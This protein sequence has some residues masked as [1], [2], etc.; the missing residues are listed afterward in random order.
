VRK[1]N[2][3]VGCVW[4]IGERKWGGDFRRRMMMFGSMVESV[5]MYGTEIWGWKEQE[6]VE[7]VHEKYLRWVLG[8]T[9]RYIVREECKRS[10]LKLKAGKRA[11]KCEDRMGERE[12]CT[13]LSE[14]YR[15]KKKNEDEKEKEKYCRRNG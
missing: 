10:K 12:E 11:A 3:V 8:E 4:G 14:C 2:K 13:I 7:K 6:E 15:E 9:P 1:A 5:L